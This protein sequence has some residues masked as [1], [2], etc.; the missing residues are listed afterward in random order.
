MSST[1]SAGNIWA[2]V[3]VLLLLLFHFKW[4]V[5]Y[6]ARGLLFDGFCMFAGFAI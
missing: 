2:F 4:G 3:A 6:L 5:K 1:C